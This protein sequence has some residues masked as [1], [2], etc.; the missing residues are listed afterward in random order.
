[1]ATTRERKVT[2]DEEEGPLSFPQAVRPARR[3]G[4]GR[5]LLGGLLI[6][7]VIAAAVFSFPKLMSSFTSSSQ[8]LKAMTH[9]VARGSLMITVTEDGNVESA[10]NVD[11]KCKVKGGGTILSIVEDG[12]HV[13]KG[14]EIIRLD[15]SSLEE[16][17]DTQ[18]IIYERALASKIQA[19]EM[20]E[21]AVISVKEYAEGTY[22]KELQD[23]ETQIR[24][25]QQNL[26]SAKNLLKFS[27]TN[28]RKGFQGQLQLD[29]DKFAVER[30]ELELASAETT[31][32]VLMEFTREKT[33][34]V[35]N[36]DREASLA[37]KRS[38]EVALGLEKSR[39]ERLRKQLENCVIL[40]PQKGMVVYANQQSRRSAEIQIEE[41]SQVREQQTIVRIPD[42]SN[43]QVKV[44]VHETRVEQI[45]P[46]MPARI[47]IQD[48]K[49]TGTVERIANQP[50]PGN[51][52]STG[53]KEYSTIVKIKNEAGATYNLKPG[54]SA[55]VEILIEER[56]DVLT[57]PVQAVVE[58]LG[59]FYCWVDVP[60]QE[61][62]E[63]RPVLLGSTNDKLIEIKDG[64]NEGDQV[65]LNPRATVKE[66]REEKSAPGG[67]QDKKFSEDALKQS[68][69]QQAKAENEKPAGGSPK[70]GPG[71]GQ[72]GQRRGRGNL[73]QSDTDGDGK[74]SKD[75]SPEW[76]RDRFDSFDTNGDGFI[77]KAEIAEMRKRFRQPGQGGA[78]R[79]GSGSG[80]GEGGN[81]G[82]TAA[83]P[84][85]GV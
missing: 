34:K 24:I 74:I 49:L 39:L 30:A 73:M 4:A 1:M 28:F 31:K 20:Y 61:K 58:Q 25:A 56:R 83:D 81:C 36:A 63:R 40:A 14:E 22:V 12:K 57:V 7:G 29:A 8:Q 16:L 77:D 21:S 59:K 41:G 64:L 54:M 2:A 80:G 18:E 19:Q 43:M 27:E 62:P 35:L 78:P 6:V 52:M 60:D 26:S 5:W 42:L 51:W 76:M 17:V 15:P 50:E 44:A 85:A 72:T 45:K 46:G 65:L 79:P 11:V 55:Q 23:A 66:A 3:S 37:H 47:V 33:L 53:I 70:L 48:Q 32:K 69:E 84:A 13:E 9:T 82:E 10:Q 38:E 71:G 68:R 67:Q 75:E